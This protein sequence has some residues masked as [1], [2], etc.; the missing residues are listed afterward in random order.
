[1]T[2]RLARTIHREVDG[3]PAYGPLI[4]TFSEGGLVLRE[5]G[6][7]TETARMS[8]ASLYERGLILKAE[9][10]PTLAKRRSRRRDGR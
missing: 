4:A 6:H 1:M 5:K 7:Q 2:T 3:G 9:S 8:W 10:M